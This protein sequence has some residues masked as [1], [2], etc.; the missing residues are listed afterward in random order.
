M[1]P[2]DLDITPRIASEQLFTWAHRGPSDKLVVCFSGIGK[3]V[4]VCPPIEF[5][6][7]ASGN[8]Q[9]NVLFI[10]DPNRTW[11]NGPDLLGRIGAEIEAYRQICGAA[12]IM[13]MGHSMGGFSA[14]VASSITHIDEVLAF[15]PQIS[16][17]PDIVPDET[18]WANYRKN[19]TQYRIISAADHFNGDTAYT[20]IHGRHGREAPQRDRFPGRENLRHY[21]MPQT[22]HNVPQRL[23]NLNCLEEVVNLSIEGK[24]HQLMLLL[25]KT[26]AILKPQHPPS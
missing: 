11:L 2:P 5:A 13:A 4:N 6:R 14:I 9:N 10:V 22:H 7:T 1:S 8:G 16:V 18:R 17:H 25:T 3:H 19:I 12:R 15:A 20:V 21:V 23:R 26:G 24:P